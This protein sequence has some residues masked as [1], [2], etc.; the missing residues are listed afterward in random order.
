MPTPAFRPKVFVSYSHR[1]RELKEKFDDNLRVLRD[2]QI[3]DCWTDGEILPGDHWPDEITNALNQADLILFLVSNHFLA[4]SFIRQKEAPM[5]MARQNRGEA[6]IVP[7][8]LSKTPGWQKEDWNTLQALPSQVKPIDHPDWRTPENAFAEV[9]EKLRELIENLPEKLA[10]QVT[11][12]RAARNGDEAPT[13]RP[14]TAPDPHPVKASPL[15]WLAAAAVLTLGVY[16]G[17]QFRQPSSASASAPAPAPAS[18][19]PISPELQA[20][21]K[22]PKVDRTVLEVFA[23]KGNG[24]FQNGL[25]E[26]TTGTEIVAARRAHQ[27]DWEDAAGKP[28]RAANGLAWE[29]VIKGVAAPITKPLTITTWFAAEK[30]SSSNAG[31]SGIK[32]DPDDMTSYTPSD[33]SNSPPG[34]NY[35]NSTINIPAPQWEHP[36]VSTNFFV[37]TRGSIPGGIHR[38]AFEIRQ[39]GRLVYRGLMNLKVPP[40]VYSQSREEWV[41]DV[42]K[43][44]LDVSLV[45][46]SSSWPSA[47]TISWKVQIK[48]D[49]AE[50]LT[51]LAFHCY[52]TASDAHSTQPQAWMVDPH[53]GAPSERSIEIDGFNRR[54]FQWGNGWEKEPV[55]VLKDGNAIQLLSLHGGPRGKFQG[56]THE[57]AVEMYSHGDPVW[58]GFLKLDLPQQ[59][60]SLPEEKN[61]LTLTDINGKDVRGTYIAGRRAKPFIAE[62][63]NRPVGLSFGPLRV[64]NK[65]EALTGPFL[66][67]FHLKATAAPQKPT[68]FAT[69]SVGTKVCPITSPPNE[70]GFNA[71][72][73]GVLPLTNQT[74]VKGAFDQIE[75]DIYV[76][77]TSDH[78]GEIPAGLHEVGIEIVDKDNVQ[79]YRGTVYVQLP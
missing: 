57:V 69:M 53:R 35:A 62:G 73:T 17:V 77:D 1:D 50:S 68:G 22:A 13:R 47:E 38:A 11:Q 52:Y 32:V 37:G 56:G 65:G 42:P 60:W 76:G 33:A 6:V 43:S 64:V 58:R 23:A 5:S 3:I 46:A 75:P 48:G 30:A 21:L 41:R 59:P 8:I 16:L 61:K 7:I 74:G 4:S 15:K 55:S 18:P 79:L 9:E 24:L 34:F 29:M 25:Q 36:S 39:E 2:Q 51:Q 44:K 20:W 71:V 49:P 27:L 26:L 66:M 72:A 14:S 70:G 19:P 78:P 63:K 54:E 45:P 12:W 28:L 10:K 40:L 31:S 67:L